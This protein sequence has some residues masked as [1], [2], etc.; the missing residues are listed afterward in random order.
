MTQLE[1]LDALLRAAGIAR[2]DAMKDNLFGS[3]SGL[4]LVNAAFDLFECDGLYDL[5]GDVRHELGITRDG[6]RMGEAA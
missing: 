2:K 6:E 1:K 3:Y 5:A 4:A